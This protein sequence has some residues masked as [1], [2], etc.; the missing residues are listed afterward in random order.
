MDAHYK[1]CAL[2]AY[3]ILMERAKDAGNRPLLREL[4]REYR[5]ILKPPITA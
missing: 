2:A 3:A 1:E 4:R 5:E